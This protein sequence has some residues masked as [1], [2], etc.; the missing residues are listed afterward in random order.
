[1]DLVAWIAL[2]VGGAGLLA[3]RE[4]LRT[5]TAAAVVVVRDER[6]EVPRGRQHRR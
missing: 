2:L 6:A 4:A 5:G 1:M 3:I